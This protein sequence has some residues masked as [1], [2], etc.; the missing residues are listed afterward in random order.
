MCNKQQQPEKRGV[1]IFEQQTSNSSRASEAEVDRGA[2]G[3]RDEDHGVAAVPL[4][5]MELHN[6]APST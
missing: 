4:L 5:P 6:G 2:P 1:R 3:V